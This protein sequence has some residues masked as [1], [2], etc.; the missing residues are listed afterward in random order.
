MKATER[1]RAERALDEIERAKDSQELAWP[2]ASS[3][4]RE[5]RL[6]TGLDERDLANRVPCSVESYSDLEAYDDEMF[7]VATLKAL[8]AIGE[9]LAVEPRVLLLGPEAAGIQ[10]TI[11]FEDVAAK[12]AQLRRD[13][14]GSAQQLEDE[15]GFRIDDIGT[16]KALWIC[17]V[18]ALYQ[19]CKSVHVDWVK[20]LPSLS[21]S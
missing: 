12:L 11:T 15:I 18:E 20:A 2:S 9:V 14:H 13:P 8:T 21:R 16:G 10:N 17:T 7:T 6:K 3:R 1:L 19:I 4:L 5:A